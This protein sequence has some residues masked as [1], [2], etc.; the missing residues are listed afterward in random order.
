MKPDGLVIVVWALVFAM[1]CLLLLTEM[2]PVRTIGDPIHRFGPPTGALC[3][4]L[5]YLVANETV[6]QRLVVAGL[7][8]YL[9]SVV[10]AVIREIRRRRS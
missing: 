8:A 1:S 2:R 4:L 9:A 7:A 5:S 6:R 10:T 3:L